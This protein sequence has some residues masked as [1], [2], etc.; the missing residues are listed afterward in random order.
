MIDVRANGLPIRVLG[1][2][3][4][5]G[6][7]RLDVLAFEIGARADVGVALGEPGSEQAQVQLNVLDGRRAQAEAPRPLLDVTLGVVAV[8]SGS[9]DPSRSR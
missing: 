6:L 2:I 4:A 5:P 1:W 9:G 8:K 3:A 7:E